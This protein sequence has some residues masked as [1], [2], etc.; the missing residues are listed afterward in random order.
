MVSEARRRKKEIAASFSDYL[1][2]AGDTSC[3]NVT[4]SL[5]S[6]LTFDLGGRVRQ[7]TRRGAVDVG[8]AVL[9]IRGG[10]WRVSNVSASRITSTRLSDGDMTA[11]RLALAGTR[12]TQVE[13]SLNSLIFSFDDVRLH[14]DLTNRW[15]QAD[16]EEIC[17][18]TLTGSVALAVYPHGVL[19]VWPLNSVVEKAA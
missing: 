9:S 6:W 11:L 19:R 12:L 1:R 16:D 3:W 13:A 7:K 17:L 18:L 10:Y 14:V 15:E 8:T 2:A 4:R 5:G